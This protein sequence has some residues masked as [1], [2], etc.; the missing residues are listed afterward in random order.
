AITRRFPDLGDRIEVA[1]SP[2]LDVI[3]P[4][5]RQI[6]DPEAKRIRAEHGP[7]VLFNSNFGSIN[8]IW[9]DLQMVVNIAARAG[10]FDPNDPHSVEQFKATLAWE[11]INYRS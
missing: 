4:K 1:G 3:G 5:G 10:A 8:S 2:R 7:F 6:F 11:E 9:R